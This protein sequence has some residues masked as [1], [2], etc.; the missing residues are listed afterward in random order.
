MRG[1]R[2]GKEGGSD[3]TFFKGMMQFL[4]QAKSMEILSKVK[5]FFVFHISIGRD[6]E[7]S[8]CAKYFYS[9]FRRR[10]CSMRVM[11]YYAKVSRRSIL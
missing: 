3:V 4:V 6:G 7:F 1:H 10:K 2:G 5:F 9:M 8:I 11:Q